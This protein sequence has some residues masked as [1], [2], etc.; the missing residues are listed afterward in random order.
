MLALPNHGIDH[1]VRVH[2]SDLAVFCDWL[3]STAL[4][5]EREVSQSDVVDFL[6]EQQIYDDNNP[7]FCME[8]VTSAWRELRR[9]LGWIGR[10][11]P[12]HVRDQ[13]IVRR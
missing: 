8:F 12:L 6:F 7:D 5:D 4:F 10:G 2:N 1:S 3:E 9:R 11:S 13:T